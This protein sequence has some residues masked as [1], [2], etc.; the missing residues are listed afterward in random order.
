MGVYRILCRSLNLFALKLEKQKNDA[1]IWRDTCLCYFQKFSR[2]TDRE[3]N[4]KDLQ[5]TERDKK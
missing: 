2:K 5:D 1:E 3:A 4:F